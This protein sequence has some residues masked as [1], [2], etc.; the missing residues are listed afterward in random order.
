MTYLPKCGNP[1]PHYFHTYMDHHFK[2]WWCGG[3][4]DCRLYEAHSPGRHK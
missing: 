4:C 1:E 3:L 2:E